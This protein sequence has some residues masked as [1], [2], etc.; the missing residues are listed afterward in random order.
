ML[1]ILSIVPCFG[2]R[3][4][5]SRPH[6]ITRR[7]TNQSRLSDAVSIVWVRHPRVIE[8]HQDLRTFPIHCF[9]SFLL[10]LFP[11]STLPSPSINCGDRQ[12]P[13][14]GSQHWTVILPQ[15]RIRPSLPFSMNRMHAS[16][17]S[18][19]HIQCLSRSMSTNRLFRRWR[20]CVTRGFRLVSFASLGHHHLQ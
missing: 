9:F 17:I 16:C 4:C 7:Q 10:S 11:I 13:G 6:A 14:I 2:Y 3:C 8:L 19:S 12:S 5:L 1:C 20:G 15:A 18:V